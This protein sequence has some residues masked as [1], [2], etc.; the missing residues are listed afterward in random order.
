[1]QKQKKQ[2]IIMIVLLL[3]AVGGYFL[4]T[5]LGEKEA[6]EADT[7]TESYTLTDFDSA[8]VTKLT[9]TNDS[10]TYSFVKDGENWMSETDT[11]IDIEE[12]TI[13]SMTAILAPLKSSDRIEK[14]EDLSQFGLDVPTKTLL[15]SDG[16]TSA[17]ILV[18]DL[19]ASISKYY[20][21]L[22]DDQT[23]VYTMDS[24]SV[25]TFDKTLEDCVVQ[26]TTTE[27]DESATTVQTED[28]TGTEEVTETE[29]VTE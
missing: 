25:T 15:V 5:H 17:T 28:V 26:Q 29:S 8:N 13:N 9:F 2:I 20:V 18:G 1:M 11:S 3:L 10:G 4:A 6:A 16:T 22:E 7:S 19:N 23:T 21:C 12:S 27:A 24:S 14:V